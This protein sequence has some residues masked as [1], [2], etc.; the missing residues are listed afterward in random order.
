VVIID[1]QMAKKIFPDQD[2]IGQRVR[3]T[4][5]PRDGSPNELEVSAW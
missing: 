2:P 5:P 3:Y 4:L 1:E